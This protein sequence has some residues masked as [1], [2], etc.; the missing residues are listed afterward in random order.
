MYLVTHL[1]FYICVNDVHELPEDDQD[2]LELGQ[3]ANCQ[4]FH[5]IRCM[6]LFIWP[7]LYHQELVN[8]ISASLQHSLFS[9]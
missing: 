9:W 7:H 6:V 2:M 4:S 1:C 8:Q 3:I 5:F